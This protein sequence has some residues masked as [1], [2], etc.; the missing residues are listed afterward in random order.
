MHKYSAVHCMSHT[1]AGASLQCSINAD[2]SGVALNRARQ[3]PDIC[4]R[5]SPMATCMGIE[6]CSQHTTQ[7]HQ[8]C[9]P[10]WACSAA[11]CVTW[12]LTD[13]PNSVRAC[14]TVH[15]QPVPQGLGSGLAGCPLNVNELRAALRLLAAIAQPSDA[16]GLRDLQRALKRGQLLVPSAPGELAPLGSCTH[17]HTA[18]TRLLNRSVPPLSLSSRYTACFAVVSC[19]SAG[20]LLVTDNM[21]CRTS[22]V[23]PA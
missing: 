17:M 21:R 23:D 12:H 13:L 5:N 20:C 15:R 8:T 19:R 11:M 7:H 4:K 22:L 3:G 14:L 10:G 2:S 18:P 6:L 1:A 16:Q 9:H